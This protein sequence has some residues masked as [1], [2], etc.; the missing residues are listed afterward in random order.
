MMLARDIPRSFGVCLTYEASLMEILTS[1]LLTLNPA[2]R[3]PG[4]IRL[5]KV[6]SVWHS[7][8][9]RS[10]GYRMIDVDMLIGPLSVSERIQCVY[11]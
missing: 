2:T 9:S 1:S 5:A 3:S 4:R 7:R 8:F 10:D 11:P 6:S